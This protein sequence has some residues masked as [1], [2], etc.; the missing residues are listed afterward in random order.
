MMS[1]N[2]EN[3][4]YEHKPSVREHA[5]ARREKQDPEAGFEPLSLWFF[6]IC[7]CVLMVGGGYLGAKS[8]GFD[9]GS[10]QVSGYKAGAPPNF[11]PVG[12]VLSERDKYFKA[13]E[14]VYKTV[15]N[16]CHQANGRGQGQ[17]PP[18]VDSGWVTNG[19]ERMAQIV[20]NGIR[21]PITVNG[22]SYGAQ[23]MPAQKGA[24]SDQ[25]IAQV[26]T[27]VRERFGGIADAVVTKEMIADARNRHGDR[28][29]QYTAGELAAQDAMLPGEQPAWMNPETD[30][31]EG[32]TSGE[33]KNSGDEQDPAVNDKAPE[34]KE[35][36]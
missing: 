20:L 15:C 35:T 36:K 22:T 16:G 8:A 10:I 17:I 18:L 1:E 29:A 13:G 23:E 11:T 4:D 34:S 21:G 6:S 5:S 19:T 33:E 32:E 12:P 2:N 9:F 3:R 28:V 14:A 27:Y 26:I 7:A 24:L 31:G 25:R 30:A